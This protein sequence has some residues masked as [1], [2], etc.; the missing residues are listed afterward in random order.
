MNTPGIWTNKERCGGRPCIRG[1]RFSISQLLAELSVRENIHE[2]ADN[3]HIN[4]KEI[5][6]ALK[7]LSYGMNLN[8][9]IL[10]KN[11]QK[12]YIF[13]I[14]RDLA[15]NSIEITSNNYDVKVQDIKSSLDNLAEWLNLIYE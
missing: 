6:V 12:V 5:N 7:D 2:I 10:N 4:V 3:F 8:D 11:N 9:F 13:T 14:L 15:E 1:H